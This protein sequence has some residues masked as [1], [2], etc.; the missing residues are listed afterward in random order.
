[1]VSIKAS[2]PIE[3][4]KKGDHMKI[5]GKAYEVDAHYVLID[6]GST[7]E[8]AIELFDPKNEELDY[9]LRYFHDQPEDT[10]EFYELVKGVMYQPREIS[11][12]EW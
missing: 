8:M 1:M 10:L 5:D 11:K 2:K 4:I 6:H 3:K 7:K 9:Q 12:V